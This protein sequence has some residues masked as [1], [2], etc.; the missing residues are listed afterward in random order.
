MTVVFLSN[1][2]NHHQKYFSDAMYKL[3]GDGYTFMETSEMRE[4]RRQLG[5]GIDTLPP[6]VKRL[7]NDS[8]HFF[9][10]LSLINEADVVIVGSAPE[11]FL[12]Y[13][14]K[15]NQLMFRYQERMF[16]QKLSFIQKLKRTMAY[17]LYN[18]KGKEIYLLC[19]SAY[20]AAD[21]GKIGLFRDRTYKW[22]YFP[23]FKEYDVDSLLAKKV[24]NKILWCGRFIDWKHPEYA[25][26]VANRLKNEGYDFSIDF[27]GTGLLEEELKREVEKLGL[28]KEITF[29][30]AMKP[31]QVRLYMETSAIFMFT[32]NFEEGWGAVLNEAMNGGCA[33]IASHAAGSTPFL[34]KHRENGLIFENENENDLYCNV[35]YILDHPEEQKRLGV[36]AYKTIAEN[37][38]PSVAAERFLALAESIRTNSQCDLFSEG[39]CSRADIM[40]NDWFMG[41][42]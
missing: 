18:S 15:R 6:Y 16:K 3:I 8:E 25:I 41:E 39:P 37:W 17:R 4:E 34:M 24:K 5:Y 35:K 42:K 38:N 32:S 11:K 1:Y 33:V 21:Y 22:G 23:D 14:K 40:E 10:C 28:E 30:G 36:N 7:Y 29:L 26:Y 9:Q 12:R 19:A 2:F 31:E 27:I 20:A 13:R